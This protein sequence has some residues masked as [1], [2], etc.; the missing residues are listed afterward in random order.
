MLAMMTRALLN[1]MAATTSSSY[2]A[3]HT[4]LGKTLMPFALTHGY[5]N[6]FE[7]GAAMLAL[8]A[9]V[10]VFTIRVGKDSLVEA[11]EIAHFG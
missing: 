3:T 2:V 9:V 4:S 1:I 5:T 6:A 11:N 8:D 10:V 7:A